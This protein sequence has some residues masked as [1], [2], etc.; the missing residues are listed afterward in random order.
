[1]WKWR[2]FSSDHY[3]WKWNLYLTYHCQMS[4]RYKVAKVAVP[5]KSTSS[6]PTYLHGIIHQPPTDRRIQSFLHYLPLC[7]V[8]LFSSVSLSGRSNIRLSC[9]YLLAVLV[10]IEACPPYHKSHSPG[11]CHD[12]VIKH[13][14]LHFQNHILYCKG[15]LLFI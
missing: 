5:S 9:W 7:S 15:Q 14:F 2:L 1:M 12:S 13:S 6:P 8:L 4:V 11:K 10:L 3:Q